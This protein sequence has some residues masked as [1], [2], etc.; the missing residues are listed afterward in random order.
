VLIGQR[1]RVRGAD[2]PVR[3]PPR[4]VLEVEGGLGHV[5]QNGG[6][7]Q[8]LKGEV[9][10]P[11]VLFALHSDGLRSRSQWFISPLRYRGRLLTQSCNV[12]SGETGEY[13]H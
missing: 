5:G 1:V 13:T 2:R 9:N 11:T 3:S 4:E 7:A 10:T 6:L 8:D 12:T